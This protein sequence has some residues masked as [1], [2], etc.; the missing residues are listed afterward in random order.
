M[1]EFDQQELAE[2]QFCRNMID[3]RISFILERNSS[4]SDRT[5]IEDIYQI[6]ADAADK[7]EQ[8]YEGR[9]DKR[10]A[11]VRNGRG[12]DLTYTITLIDDPNLS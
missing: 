1:D 9:M 12:V 3:A 6:Y 10:V 8:D 4:N 5:V 7:L 2:L 11:F